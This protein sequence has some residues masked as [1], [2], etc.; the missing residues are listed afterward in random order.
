MS[1]FHKWEYI[2]Y[3]P[4]NSKGSPFMSNIVKKEYVGLQQKNVV[5]SNVVTR[6]AQ[7]L[8]LSEKR[9]L[10]AAIAKMG[11]K[12]DEVQITAAEYAQTF[13]VSEVTAYEQLKQASE[14][15]WN[16]Y[17]TLDLPDRKGVTKW[18]FRWIDAYGYQDGEGFVS[19]SFSRHVVPYL[20]DLQSQFTQ[21]QL[22]QAS[23][24]RSLHSWRLM[25]LFEQMRPEKERGGW[26]TISIERFWYA[27][28]APDSYR[29]NFKDLR[30]KL[31]EPAIKELTTKDNWLIEWRA[32]KTGRK[33]TSIQFNFDKDKQGHLF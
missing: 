10:F 23:S 29:K 20:V 27:M 19:I 30:T 8:S 4:I 13:D 14:H 1:Q 11:G 6:A 17:F 3:Y 7:G 26:L 32:V 21:Y 28:E 2:I 18:R 9:I 12:F 16:R 15:F 5:M 22:K 31:I 33:V 25:E 24:L